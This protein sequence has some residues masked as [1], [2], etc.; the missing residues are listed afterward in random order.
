MI[1]VDF[2]DKISKSAGLYYKAGANLVSKNDMEKLDF[3]DRTEQAYDRTY[4][5]YDGNLF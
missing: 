3:Y 1:A 4:A 2:D 5:A